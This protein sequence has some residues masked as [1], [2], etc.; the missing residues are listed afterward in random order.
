MWSQ[1][2]I[3]P[4]YI[5]SPYLY[6]VP[7]DERIIEAKGEDTKRLVSKLSDNGQSNRWCHLKGE[8][9]SPRSRWE[10]D[11]SHTRSVFLSKYHI[12]Q[13][14]RTHEENKE[15]STYPTRVFVRIKDDTKYKKLRTLP[16]V[17]QWIERGLW[18]KGSPVL[19]PVRA[20]AWVAGQVPSRGYVRSNHTLMFLSLYFSFPSPLSKNKKIKY[21]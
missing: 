9:G 21:F 8:K 6:S 19:F 3:F 13:L 1:E 12:W 18:T 15:N 20:H 4:V 11:V 10:C 7:G 17:A 14:S 16:G 2:W 5:F